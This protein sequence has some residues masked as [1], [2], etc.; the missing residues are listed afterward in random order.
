[1]V[2]VV[3]EE[4]DD[5]EILWIK[6][7]NGKVKLKMAAV[8][9]PQESQ[10]KIGKLRKIYKDIEREVME[11][12]REKESIV[13]LG[14]FNCKVGEEIKG[15]TEE[16]TKAGKLMMELCKNTGVTIV[17]AEEKCNGLWT[18]KEGTSKSIIDYVLMWKEDVEYLDFMEIDEQQEYTPYS[19]D[20]SKTTYSDHFAIELKMNWIMKLRE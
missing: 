2:T 4:T 19:I 6:I 20:C 1:V 3:G 14:D 11:A 8:Y 15:N 9:M 12:Q 16:V 5:C 18:R 10:T 7:D 13:V 17:N